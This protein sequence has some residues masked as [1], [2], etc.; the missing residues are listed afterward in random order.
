MAPSLLRRRS[1]VVAIAAR[2]FR[3]AMSEHLERDEVDRRPPQRHCQVDDRPARPTVAA[4]G[5]HRRRVRTRRLQ[6]N[7]AQ[8]DR[9]ADEEHQ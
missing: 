1:V 9:H 3:V 7:D 4:A 8:Q 2:V 6:S 5:C